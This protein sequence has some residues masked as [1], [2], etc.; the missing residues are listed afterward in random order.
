MDDLKKRIEAIKIKLDLAKMRREAETLEKESG[1]SE[2]WQDQQTAGEKMK[3]LSYLQKEIDQIEELDS[4]LARGELQVIEKILPGIELKTFLSGEYDSLPAIMAIHAG[5]GGTEAMDW[6]EMMKRMYLMYFDRKKWSHQTVDETAGDEAGIKSVVMK[7]DAPFAYGHLKHE[8]GTHRL[9]RRSPFNADH[10]R[11]TS[12]ALVEILPQLQAEGVEIKEE[13]LEWQFFHSSSQGG[14]NVQKVSTAVRVK[15]KPTGI[16]VGA[17]SERF[18]EQNRKIALGLLRSKLWAMAEEEARRETERLKGGRKMAAW[19]MQIRSYV[20]DNKMVKDLR[21]GWETADTEKVLN[22][23]LDG[24]IE[25]ELK[26]LPS[27]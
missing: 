22:G 19:G 23:D 3:Q 10:L 4:L 16:I 14:Q 21:T 26:T 6:A 15:H 27:D 12:F 8:A 5:Q 18:Q 1:N 7:I 25:A 9:V 11:Q 2:F 17:Q 20:L 24:L 13:D